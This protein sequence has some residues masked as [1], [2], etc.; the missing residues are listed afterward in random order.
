MNLAIQ[1]DDRLSP[2]IE[3]FVAMASNPA[4]L[5]AGA[6]RRVARLHQ[7][8]F[9]ARNGR[10]N[11][12]GWPSRQFWARLQRATK[13]DSYDARQA[14]VV[15]ADPALNLRLHGGTVVPKRSKYL[16]IPARA[17]AYAA[18]S[19]REGS[20]DRLQPLI[21][22]IGG[23]ATAIALVERASSEIRFAKRKGGMKVVQTSS[24][25]GGAIWFWL[26]KSVTQRPDPSAVPTRAQIEGEVR[27]AISEW[28]DVDRIMRGRQGGPAAPRA[29]R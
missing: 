29:A 23:R 24:T 9:A 4:A 21:R 7:D 27:L 18:G 11:A 3:R 10:G 28:L 13:L 1:I 19:P 16:A 14:T 20:G 2:G 5:L 26:V 8:H 17:E 15:V 25:L 22:R 12:K 6:G